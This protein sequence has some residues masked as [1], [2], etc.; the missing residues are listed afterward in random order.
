MA[1]RAL[2]LV[3]ALALAGCSAFGAGG[4]V[5]RLHVDAR[6]QACVGAAVQQCL[7]VRS[8]P[9]G[10]WTLFYGTIEGFDYEP[11]FV[12]V[13]DVEV[14]RVANPPAD[15]SSLAYRLVRVVDKRAA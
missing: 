4:A 6:T 1:A 13:L 2:V 9:D 14:R 8:T 7:R 10:E 5:Q 15:G 12:Y 11:G 3:G